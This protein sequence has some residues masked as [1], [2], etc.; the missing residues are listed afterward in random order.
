MRGV[1]TATV[2]VKAAAV[3]SAVERLLTIVIWKEATRAWEA[4][5]GGQTLG[6]TTGTKV[7]FGGS[8]G[9]GVT[10]GGGKADPRTDCHTDGA[11]REIGDTDKSE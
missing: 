10:E 2:L 9:A 6:K 4:A 5:G 1:V 8:A 11:F 3:R 7:F